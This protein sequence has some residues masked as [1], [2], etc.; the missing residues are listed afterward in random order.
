MGTQGLEAGASALNV[1]DSGRKKCFQATDLRALFKMVKIH[2]VY[3][4][5]CGGP[6]LTNTSR[7]AMQ[8]GCFSRFCVRYGH[9]VKMAEEMAS[10]IT[11]SLRSPVF[12][13]FLH[14]CHSSGRRQR[15]CHFP[16]ITRICPPPHHSSLTA[17]LLLQ[18][19]KPAG[20]RDI[21]RVCSREDARSSQ[22]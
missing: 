8:H 10:A 4:S 14:A 9:I 7:P 15:G 19:H 21:A 16:S 12:E 3:Y 6:L 1:L 13:T 2:I 5:T 18:T 22:G 17:E 20:S 11:V